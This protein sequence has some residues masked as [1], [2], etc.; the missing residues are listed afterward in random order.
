[1]K[2]ILLI[3][4]AIVYAIV[5]ISL[6]FTLAS[7]VVFLIVDGTLTSTAQTTNLGWWGLLLIFILTFVFAGVWGKIDTR[8]RKKRTTLCKICFV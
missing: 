6:C 8:I 1:M 5:G 2:S 4:L 3:L 7:A